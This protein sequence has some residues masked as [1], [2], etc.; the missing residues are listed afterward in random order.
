MTSIHIYMYVVN[1]RVDVLSAMLQ[2]GCSPIPWGKGGCTPLH[3][4]VQISALTQSKLLKMNKLTLLMV[5]FPCF[6]VPLF[7]CLNILFLAATE[8]S[9][10]AALGQNI[11]QCVRVCMLY[12]LDCNMWHQCC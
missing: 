12:D 8:E 1:G 4:A 11:A 2:Y 7:A 6:C 10:E 5:N 9:E 3:L